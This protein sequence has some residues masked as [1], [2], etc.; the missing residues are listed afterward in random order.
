MKIDIIDKIETFEAI[1]EN[2]DHIYDA[3]PQAQF[4][5]SWTWISAIL[6]RDKMPW[7][8]LAVKLS[9]DASDYLGFFPLTIELDRNDGG[10]FY[11]RL[12]IVGVTDADHPGF[13]C[14]PE[15]E[16]DIVSTFAQYLQ[17]QE[18][19]SVFK[20]SNILK[21]DT[22][23][24][25]FL[26]DFAQESFDSRELGEENYKNPLDNITNQIL[27]YITLPDSWELY[28][29]NVLSSNTRQ[30]IRRFFRKIE[31][32][33]EFRITD[34]NAENLESH[35]EIISEFWQANWESRK[36]V[37]RC[38]SILRSMVF[39]LRH[40]FENNSLYLP[41]FWKGDKPL[42]AIANLIDFRKKSMIF[43][44]GGRDETFKELPPGFVLHAYAIRYA[45]QN[46]FKIYD[47]QMGNEA[48]KY[49]FGAK[50]RCIQTTVV[51]RKDWI[52]QSR[53]LDVRT[54]PA[55]LGISKNYHRANRLVEAEQGYRQ[56]LE[57]QP[58]N[59]K[60]LN[61]LAVIA[62][63]K[64][65]FKTAENL[66]TNLLQ[67]QPN[68]T[69][70]W[71]SLGTVH[72]IQN[73]LSEAEKAYRQAL[74]LKPDSSAVSS[75]I[76]HNLGYALQQQDKW[77][78]AIACYQ[79]ARELN[80]DS[81]EI[82]VIWANALYAQGKLSSEQQTHYAAANNDLGNKRKQAGEF[83]VAIEYYR[84]AIA[85]N[86]DL[87]EAH[88]N[89][90]LSLQ[91]QSESNLEESITCYQKALALKPNFIL[92][93]VGLANALYA[94]GKLSP[95]QQ[96]E[97]AVLNNNLGNQYMEAG[98]FKVAIE[99][100]RQAIALNRDLAEAHYNLGL[101]LQK[102]SKSNWEKSIACYQK[103]LALK[104]NFILADV[105]LANALYDQ[106]KLSPEQ[107]IHY[108]LLNNDLGNQCRQANDLK[109][110]I[111]YYNQAITLN[112]DLAEARDNLRLA[113]E[114]KEDKTIKLSCAKK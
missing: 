80:P 110:A 105:G 104:P 1:R 46:R 99:Y 43:F 45:I 15:Y 66:L 18:T 20:I 28:L 2:W 33:N 34:V 111:E 71:F 106:G 23:M 30:K 38:K 64:G 40:C 53:K 103:A 87:A 63:R 58:Q 54:L 11:N 94:Q 36:G 60:A 4:F 84:Q 17:Q 50:D 16:K 6:K 83:K 77:D 79:K 97:Y 70:V 21:A 24:S 82:E 65:E 98:E 75:A 27:P 42:G 52:N 48:Y 35:I 7:F 114:E 81:I 88:Y 69:R 56:I 19:W 10:R 90:G 89:L 72:Q 39:E 108:A 9:S 49:S 26:N 92:A 13:L 102:Q 86:P 59:S 22:R 51:E 37:E 8:I 96:V 47:F 73:Q 29:Q 74:T 101:S 32:S 93:D 95:E 78:E 12:S 76:Y 100:Y 5:V 109:A 55:A 31:N 107:Q 91:K 68:N 25:L 113:L 85:L 3:D 112:R 67:I 41:V 44:V 62:Q 61:G 57:V 14:L